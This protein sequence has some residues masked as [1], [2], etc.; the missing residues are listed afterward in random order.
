M[1]SLKLRFVLAGFSRRLASKAEA[2][3][4]LQSMRDDLDQALDAFM[5]LAEQS[6][7]KQ[8]AAAAIPQPATPTAKVK[9]KPRVSRKSAAAVP[10]ATLEVREAA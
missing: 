2:G 9:R 6:A 10:D 5:A 7:P 1:E 3:A 8:K 4:T